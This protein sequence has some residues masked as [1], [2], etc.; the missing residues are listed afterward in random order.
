M[1]EE[2]RRR[3]CAEKYWSARTTLRSL[4]TYTDKVVYTPVACPNSPAT[5]SSGVRSIWGRFAPFIF[6]ACSTGAADKLSQAVLPG[7]WRL[8][9]QTVQLIWR[10]FGLEG[11]SV[12]KHDWVIR[13]L[14]GGKKVESSTPPPLYT[15]LGPV[16]SAHSTTVGPIRAFADSRA[17]VTKKMKT[18]LLLALAFIKRVGDIS[19]DDLCLEF[20]PADS[21]IILRPGYVLEVPT[22][23]FRA[24]WWA[25]KRCPGGGGLSPSF[26]LSC[27]SIEML[28]WQDCKASGPQTSSLSA[29]E[30]GRRGIPSPCRGWPTG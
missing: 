24:R 12:G 14:K 4:H 7:E 26:A 23:P 21:Q 6:W 28:R 13:F 15:L 1:A 29:T 11:K 30:A 18:L 2:V 27:P 9:P 5:S 20:G 22:T 8:H 3:A 25:C 16:S 17:E 10:R 19:V